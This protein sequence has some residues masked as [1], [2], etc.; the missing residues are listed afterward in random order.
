MSPQSIELFFSLALGFAFA[1]MLGTGY[2][3]ATSRPAGFYLLERGPRPSTFAAV[4]FLVFA[5]PFIIMRNTIPGHVIEG[6]SIQSVLIPT[7]IA[8]LWT[9]MWGPDAPSAAC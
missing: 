9:L 6:R 7:A 2:Q 5:A 4:P 1:G 8:R 3:L